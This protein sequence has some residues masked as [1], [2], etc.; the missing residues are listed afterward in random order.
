MTARYQVL[1]FT[2]KAVNCINTSISSST[3]LQYLSSGYW[4]SLT[5]PAQRGEVVSCRHVHFVWGRSF[6]S[7]W[8]EARS[9]RCLD[10]LEVACLIWLSCRHIQ[11]S[12]Q[13]VQNEAAMNTQTASPCMNE[14]W[15]PSRKTAGWVYVYNLFLTETEQKQSVVLSTPVSSLVGDQWGIRLSS[16]Y[17][18]D[19]AFLC[20]KYLAPRE[21]WLATSKYQVLILYT[22]AWFLYNVHPV[23]LLQLFPH[24]TEILQ[25]A[26]IIMGYN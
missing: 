7:V 10:G 14:N 15:A 26:T 4:P 13:D 21:K 18:L 11:W 25:W 2:L 3:V 6:H 1:I 19:E 17:W 20:S 8:Q 22:V 16:F 24:I 12:K 23:N 5:A 9:S